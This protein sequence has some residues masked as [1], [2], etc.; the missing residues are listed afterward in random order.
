M[1]IG[2]YYHTLEEKGRLSLPKKFREESSTWVVTRGL[3]GCLFLFTS[4]QYAQEMQQISGSSFT[5]KSNRDFSRLMTTEA[6]EVEVDK[7]GRVQLP[8]YLIE[9]AALDKHVAVTGNF[10]RIEIW[11]REA[12]H[13]YLDSLENS[14]ES[15]A[16]SFEIIE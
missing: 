14:A 9:K 5:K 2:T 11:N 8:E 1:L 16:E 7:N 3:D 13:A 12:Y 15:I 10:S 4:D 6:Y